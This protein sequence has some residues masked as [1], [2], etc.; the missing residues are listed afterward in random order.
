MGDPGSIPG[1]GNGK[2]LQYSC[3]K[4]LHGQRSLA[5]YSPWDHRELDTTTH[6]GFDGHCQHSV[7]KNSSNSH[8]FCYFSIAPEVLK[9]ANDFISFK[10]YSKLTIEPLCPQ[11]LTFKRENF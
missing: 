1:E 4:N 11:E 8:S 7:H 2:S 9:A 10:C 5:G 3:L 6:L